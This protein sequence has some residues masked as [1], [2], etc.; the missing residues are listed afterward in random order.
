MWDSFENIEK[1]GF[2]D[3]CAAN[4]VLKNGDIGTLRLRGF[5]CS[6]CGRCFVYR[7]G[8]SLRE[9]APRI[10]AAAPF[11]HEIVEQLRGRIVG[12]N[13]KGFTVRNIE[14]SREF[15]GFPTFDFRDLTLPD[16]GI[17]MHLEKQVWIC[18]YRYY[19]RFDRTEFLWDCY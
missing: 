10:Y 5:Q 17:A 9:V 11:D 2:N 1:D 4:S 15:A 14:P 19:N 13:A 12:V 18:C 7:F 16:N 8:G 6:V 3:C